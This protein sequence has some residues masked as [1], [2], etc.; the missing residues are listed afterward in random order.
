MDNIYHP[1]VFVTDQYESVNDL[2]QLS[3]QA[4]VLFSSVYELGCN[5]RKNASQTT[6]ATALYGVGVD[7]CAYDPWKSVAEG[8]SCLQNDIVSSQWWVYFL[9]CLNC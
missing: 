3:L 2:R 5:M 4:C 7:A 1:S 9:L 6:I 8:I